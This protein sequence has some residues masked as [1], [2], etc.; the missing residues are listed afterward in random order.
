MGERKF[1]YKCMEKFD[2]D[3]HICPSCGYDDTTPNNPMYITPGTILRDRYLVGILMDSNGEGVTYTGYDISTGG[4]VIIREYMPVNLCTRVRN[5]ATISVNYNNLAKYKAFMAEYTEL[6]KSLVKLRNNPSLPT[7]LDMFSENNTTYTIFAH[8]DGVKLMDYLKDNAGELSWEKASKLFPPLLTAISLLHNNAIIHRAISPDTVFITPKNE[9]KLAGFSVSSV[10]TVNAGMEYELFRGYAAPEQYSPSSSSH[11]GT[12][13]D[14]YGICALLYRVLTGCMPT[15]SK[16]RLTKDDLIEPKSLNSTIPQHV[17]NVI[18]EGMRLKSRQRIN[19]IT[20]LVTRLFEAPGPV[21]PIKHDAGA[22][23]EATRNTSIPGQGVSAAPAQLTDP[24]MQILPPPQQ[25]PV[26]PQPVQPAAPIQPNMQQPVQYE[27]VPYQQPYPP[28]Y[29]PQAPYGYGYEQEDDYDDDY[30]YERVNTVDRLKVPVIVAILLFL[31]LMI[32]ALIFL[33]LVDPGRAQLAGNGSSVADDMIEDQESTTEAATVKLDT[34]MPQLVGKFYDL[35]LEK[36]KDFFTIE[37]IY[38]YNDDEEADVIYKQDIEPGEM[39]AQGCTVRVWVSKGKE[40]AIIPAYEGFTVMQYENRLKEAGISSYS[41]IASANEWSIPNTVTKLMIDNDEVFPG[42]YF[43]NKSNSKLIV[44]YCPSETESYNNN[45]A[46]EAVTASAITDPPI[47]T[48]TQAA[49]GYS[50]GG[51]GQGGVISPGG[52]S[53]PGGGG[54]QGGAGA[55]PGGGN[56]QGGGDTPVTP[57]PVVPDPVM[58]EPVNPD[59]GN[60]SEGGDNGGTGDGG[61]VAYW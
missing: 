34:E 23:N 3:K 49:T 33:K 7:V 38:E 46:T 50:G 9:L 28:Q 55:N 17:S 37:A 20:E 15:D 27:Q 52:G 25:Q 12:W 42:D 35:T 1:C 32:I 4:K 47:S 57:D 41:L 60:W 48:G 56:W 24:N 59:P 40:S 39:V 51:N 16:D 44:Y 29:D 22:E 21:K 2:M 5:K 6:N 26:Y 18:M 58:P 8:F 10:R 30:R 31:I 19:T 36:Y 45:Y 61:E 13:T 54:S 43:S 53:N 11:Q 14:V